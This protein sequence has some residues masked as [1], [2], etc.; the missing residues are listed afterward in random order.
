M[1]FF[2]VIFIPMLI[3]ILNEYFQ[4]K[5]FACFEKF[6]RYSKIIALFVPFILV[7]FNPV[8]VK[9][10]LVF[11]KDIDKK[12]VHQNMDN[13]MNSYFETKNRKKINYIPT[14]NQ[15]TNNNGYYN[16]VPNYQNVNQNVNQPPRNFIHKNN[17]PNKIKRNVSESKKK[18]IASNQKWRC[19]HCKNLLDNTYEV[20]HIIALYRGGTN[21]LTNLEALCRNCHGVKTF[22][23]KMNIS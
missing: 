22:K 11:F 16:N 8:L 19:T 3:F 4:N 18:Y 6:Y 10:M 2:F 13:M 7:Y 23:E 15:F 1:N 12:P 20:D 5:I 14:N 17:V 21:D 9:K